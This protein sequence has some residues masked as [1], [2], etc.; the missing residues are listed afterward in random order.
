M[1]L[2]L[3]K[4]KK[5]FSFLQKLFLIASVLPYFDAYAEATNNLDHQTDDY[6][7]CMNPRVTVRIA[8]CRLGSTHLV[9]SRPCQ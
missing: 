2:S 5:S 3:D 1:L 8:S 4:L 6:L 9:Q 7:L